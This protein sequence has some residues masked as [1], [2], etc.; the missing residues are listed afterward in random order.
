MFAIDALMALALE[1]IVEWVYG[2]V[3]GFLTTFLTIMGNMGV[4]LFELVWVESITFFFYKLGWSLYAVGIVVA[5]FE[6]AIDYQSGKANI[7][8]TG[9]NVLKGF[10]A[11]SLF[12]I[13]PVELYTMSVNLSS[14]MMKGLTG[15]T[16]DFGNMTTNLLSRILSAVTV[17]DFVDS[18]IIR[19]T[20]PVSPIL[21]IVMLFMM[22]YAIVKI[23]FANL[24]RG[25]IL[26]TQIA[27]GSLYMF[28]VPRGYS[29]GFIQWCKQVI[30]ICLTAF[31][32]L[33]LLTAG[34]L[35]LYDNWL[36]GIGL[37][38]SADEVPRIAGMFG[39][40][41]STK[42]NVMGAIHTANLAC[43]MTRNITQLV[44]K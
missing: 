31:L 44:A 18:M 10:L 13:V 27:V 29:D 33:I 8:D 34:L 12:T 21:V 15:I 3:V 32:Q 40:D 25:G 26:L 35:A 9:L 43:N 14:S 4:E 7:R 36:L 22:C 30:A 2:N 41:T 1:I 20:G 17:Q 11:V 38:M 39:L 37:M 5:V 28:S 24:K 19:F 6:C 42:A 16:G 23:F